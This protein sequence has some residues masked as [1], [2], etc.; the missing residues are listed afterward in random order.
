MARGNGTKKLGDLFSK[1]QNLKAPQGHIVEVFCEV[2]T[3]LLGVSISTTDVTYTTFNRTLSLK[4]KSALKSE[5]LLHKQEILTHLKGRL[6]PKNC[7]Q[8]IL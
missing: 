2:T 5:V 3:D 4:T 8:E 1:Y 6:G 7:P